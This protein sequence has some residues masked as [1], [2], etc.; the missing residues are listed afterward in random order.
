M[1]SGV[2]DLLA[3]VRDAGVEDKLHVVIHKPADVPVNEL[4]GITLGFA[5]D[6]LDTELINLMRGKGRKHHLVPETCEKRMPER[7]IL[8]HV[9]NARKPYRTAFCGFIGKRFVIEDTLKLDLDNA[10]PLSYRHVTAQDHIADFDFKVNDY[11]YFMENNFH[12]KAILSCT[13]A[14]DKSRAEY[15]CL[16]EEL[17]ESSN[18]CFNVTFTKVDNG[19]KADLRCS[20][21]VMSFSDNSQ[22]TTALE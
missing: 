17:S 18:K 8:V 20:R 1:I 12:G 3:L 15:F 11:K 13:E 14:D 19:Y 9:Q 7:V 6:G 21:Y 2:F 5:R 16:V 4:C 22:E 10:E